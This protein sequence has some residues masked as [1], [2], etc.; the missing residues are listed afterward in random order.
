M[1]AGRVATGVSLIQ[2]CGGSALGGGADKS[3]LINTNSGGE[4]KQSR[5]RVFSKDCGK[6][7]PDYRQEIK[8]TEIPPPARLRLQFRRTGPDYVA[9]SPHPARTAR[10]NGR[11]NENGQDITAKT[12]SRTFRRIQSGDYRHE[13]NY[14]DE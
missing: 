13:K 8:H 6:E 10:S 12:D 7:N 9:Q 1:L 11:T 2:V 4:P 3:D 5:C 14:A